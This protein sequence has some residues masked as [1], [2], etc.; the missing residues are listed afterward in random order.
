MALLA[1][2]KNPSKKELLV[3]GLGLPILFGIIGWHR[4]THGSVLAAQ[5]IWAA[6]GAL[7]LAFALIPA[8]RT[9][10]YV[11]WMYAVFPIAFVVS[12][13]IL[14]FVYFL[15][16]TPAAVVLRLA[17]KDPMNRTLDRNA[18]TYWIPRE[19]TRPKASYFRQF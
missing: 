9:K 7:T 3:F 17:G 19:A 12:H 1:I 6:G 14:A 2:N 16:L 13:V 15:I 18:K 10:I 4:W 8:A 5:V 11:G